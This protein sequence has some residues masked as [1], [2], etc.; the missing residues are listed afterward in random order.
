MWLPSTSGHEVIHP[1]GW[2][3]DVVSMRGVA[4]FEPAVSPNGVPRLCP[5][6]STTWLHTPLLHT[7]MGVSS[8]L[9]YEYLTVETKNRHY[10]RFV[11]TTAL[12]G[13]YDPVLSES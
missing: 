8:A 5:V 10:C 3:G 11:V 12:A 4:G 7:T 1:H 9:L 13:D 2:T 6:P